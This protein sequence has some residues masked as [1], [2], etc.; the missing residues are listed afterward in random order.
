LANTEFF[1][2]IEAQPE[3]FSAAQALDARVQPYRPEDDA[4][5]KAMFE[6]VD[7]ARQIGDSRWMAPVPR[8]ATPPPFPGLEGYWVAA[9]TANPLEVVGVVGAEMFD[10]SDVMAAD[11]GLRIEW[12]R[13]GRVAELRRLRVA[14]EW[15]G[16]GVGTA[17]CRE[18]I[19]WSQRDQVDILIVNTTTP[20][21]PAR[22]LYRKLGFV[23]RGLSFVGRYELVWMELSIRP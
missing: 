4:A 3:H 2:V 15:R 18:V 6:R 17:L 8:P 23:E 11:H 9:P 20:Q 7:A 14:P 1:R 12:E 16:R 13:Y 5:V 21:S 22:E 10:G 19:E